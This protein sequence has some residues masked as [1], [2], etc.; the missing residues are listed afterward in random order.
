MEASLH[1]SILKIKVALFS[2]NY[3]TNYADHH[4]VI[5][6][7][8]NSTPSIGCRV[9]SVLNSWLVEPL[10]ERQLAV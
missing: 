1:K 8:T 9:D 7:F 10:L 4:V 6:A 5:D 3:C 2:Y